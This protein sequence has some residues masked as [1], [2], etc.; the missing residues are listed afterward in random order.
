MTSAAACQGM[1]RHGKKH[2]RQGLEKAFGEILLEGFF[3]R[4]PPRP[5]LIRKGDARCQCSTAST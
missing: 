1:E 5:V 2:R 3:A 4:G